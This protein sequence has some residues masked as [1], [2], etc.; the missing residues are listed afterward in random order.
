VVD[1]LDDEQEQWEYFK[2]WIAQNGP[3][4]VAGIIVGVAGIWGWNAYKGHV[5][6]QAHAAEQQYEQVV[7]AFGRKDSA[8]AASMLAALERDHAGS[9]YVDQAR[10]AAA[11]VAVESNDLAAADTDLRAVMTG[12][13]DPELALVARLRLARVLLAEGK[14]E[15]ALGTVQGAT[16]GSAFAP[17]FA[18]V[19]GD[20]L[21]AKGDRAGALAAYREASAAK[22]AGVLDTATLDLKIRDLA[23]P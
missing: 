6:A 5:D 21:L 10:L 23:S 12:S 3:W 18:E 15:E 2:G 14:S 13:H 19:R 8:R 20:A 11:R 9:P 22:T 17:E 4:I 16:P 7:D 1:D